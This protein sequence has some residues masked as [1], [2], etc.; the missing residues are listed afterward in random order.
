MR[1]RTVFVD[2]LPYVWTV[3]KV[4]E[5][6]RECG[7]IEEVRAP[8][9]Q[10]SGRLRGFAHVT[11]SDV[12]G[13]AKALKMD[14]TQVG[15][16]LASGWD[17]DARASEK[18]SLTPNQPEIVDLRVTSNGPRCRETY[19]F[20]A[21]GCAVRRPTCQERFPGHRD[22]YGFHS[23]G[24]ANFR[25]IP[26]HVVK[27]RR[28]PR[29]RRRPRMAA[30][31][32]RLAGAGGVRM[33]SSVPL[34][35]GGGDGGPP[36]QSHSAPL[37]RRFRGAPEASS[38]RSFG[39]RL[40]LPG[41]TR[42]GR[43]PL[44]G[45]E[46]EFEDEDAEQPSL[47]R[48]EKI[49]RDT[50][51]AARQRV[52][53]SPLRAL[54]TLSPWA[55]LRL[56]VFSAKVQGKSKYMSYNL[57]PVWNPPWEVTCAIYSPLS[58][59]QVLVKDHNN[60]REFT[61]MGFVEFRVADL[62]PGQLVTGSFE[63]REAKKLKVA[64]G[65]SRLLEHE[66]CRDEVRGLD[67]PRGSDELEDDDE[68]DDE[69]VSK[70][71][72]AVGERGGA[73]TR[74]ASRLRGLLH[75]VPGVV[76]SPTLQ[77]PGAFRFSFASGSLRSGEGEVRRA[78]AG[79]LNMQLQLMPCNSRSEQWDE[80]ELF[81]F[82]FPGPQADKLGAE[83]AKIREV[84][85]TIMSIKRM[86]WDRV[87]RRTLCFLVYVMEWRCKRLTTG[88]LVG[89]WVVAI[90]PEFLLPAVLLW[91]VLLI[92]LLRKKSWQRE[93]LDESTAPLTHEGFKVVAEF[94]NTRKMA[95]WLR[96]VAFSL[97]G[98][99]VPWDGVDIPPDLYRFASVIFRDKKPS[100]Q[101]DRVCE[102]LKQQKF[103]KKNTK[104]ITCPQG[105]VLEYD[106]DMTEGTPWRCRWKKCVHAFA[107]WPCSYGSVHRYQCL[108]CSGATRGSF[109]E[110]ALPGFLRA[111]GSNL[112]R[113][114]GG[115]SAWDLPALGPAPA[116]GH[117]LREALM[118]KLPSLARRR[119]V[120]APPAL[121]SAECGPA[122]FFICE[123]CV[124]GTTTSTKMWMRVLEG[125][126]RRNQPA[127]VR[128][129]ALKSG[130]YLT[131]G[132]NC[133]AMF[134]EWTL[135]LFYQE[136]AGL[137]RK[138]QL[139]CVGAAS[140]LLIGPD[141]PY[142]KDV[143][144]TIVSWGMA[145]TWCVL[146]SA[147]L[148]W[149][150][151]V[152]VRWRTGRK[153]KVL[154]KR[155]RKRRGQSLEDRWAFFTEDPSVADEREPDTRGG[156]LGCLARPH[157]SAPEKQACLARPHAPAWAP[158]PA[159]AA[160]GRVEPRRAEGAARPAREDLRL[161]LPPYRA[162]KYL[163][164]QLQRTPWAVPIRGAFPLELLKARRT[165]CTVGNK[166]R[167]LKIEAA[168]QPGAAAAAA[169]ADP[170]QFE[171]K[172]RLFVKNLPY[173]AAESEVLALFQK[174]GKVADV[175]IPTSFGRCKES[176]QSRTKDSLPDAFPAE[177]FQDTPDP[178]GDSQAS[179]IQ[180]TAQLGLAT[181]PAVADNQHQ[182]HT[183]AQ[184]QV[185]GTGAWQTQVLC[186][187]Q[188]QQP[189]QP[190]QQAWQPS[191]GSD[192]GGHVASG[193]GD[194]TAAAGA[195]ADAWRSQP[196][197]IQSA[198][199]QPPQQAP[200]QAWQP[201]CSSGG[202]GHAAAGAAGAAA[203]AGARQQ[204]PSTGAWQTQVPC[205][206]QLQQSQQQAWQSSCD[207]GIGGHV[208]AGA[209]DVLAAAGA[210][211]DAWQSQPWQSQS[212]ARQPPRE[213]PCPSGG[214]AAA[215]AQAQPAASLQA[216]AAGGR[217]RPRPARARDEDLQ[218][219]GDRIAS[220]FAAPPAAAAAAAARGRSPRGLGGVRRV[221]QGVATPQKPGQRWGRCPSRKRRG[222]GPL[223]DPGAA[224]LPRGGAAGGP[225]AAASCAAS[226]A[227]AAARESAGLEDA[228]SENTIDQK[229]AHRHNGLHAIM[230]GEGRADY[231]EAMRLVE[232]FL[233]PADEFPAHPYAVGLGL[234]DP[235]NLCSKR[236]WERSTQKWR[237]SLKA[238]VE[239]YRP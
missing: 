182:A 213:A 93:M 144:Y 220:A 20:P 113:L 183:T 131:K 47:H 107:E 87:V 172:R 178:Y 77:L 114:T 159:V 132:R 126:P 38:L 64:P 56:R 96:R 98:K 177:E 150:W 169:A 223:D 13:Q 5:H 196:R 84:Y 214:Q 228:E 239:K 80:D 231:Q 135:R 49:S 198:A 66:E 76:A 195:C 75:D 63:L 152:F 85:E 118:S 120:R 90:W 119:G 35:S 58:I 41:A 78:N 136:G 37:L 29:P 232:E 185:L 224:K 212:A 71:D 202:G 127:R 236:E 111:R 221:P 81:A 83:E 158:H 155:Y 216:A 124:L 165:S 101:F 229:R 97:H 67:E 45:S 167:Y 4:Q 88:I 24:P 209:G 217:G 205:F 6:F 36:E 23:Q 16:T 138:F 103:F 189:Q 171:G 134:L 105:H 129:F 173:D 109:A 181:E 180:T 52:L 141:I 102:L 9:W 30:S 237:K 199:R 79:T 100:I 163:G 104:N 70:D 10:D 82:C 219:A 34:L 15:G 51:H 156:Y 193:A 149:K 74:H 33:A 22:W 32:L 99:V 179:L 203:A 161:V 191:C 48:R 139:V 62:T 225:A 128:W 27:G 123:D 94:G 184:Q 108:Q 117:G 42:V 18:P 8:T 154:V 145:V 133:L 54:E 190:Q 115:V 12:R 14:G 50:F 168:K 187:L 166:G 140:L 204:V 153:A 106:A 68:D 211:A 230:H 19:E 72:S 86:L 65:S 208:A 25:P 186:F 157:A 200:Q 125:M 215:R 73:L 151:K 95:W 174:C 1:D 234:D 235:G 143:L 147:V 2:G 201:P 55:R 69:T 226:C 43:G 122:D 28:G 233:A 39:A 40:S 175:R 176:S 222:G 188:L 21:T 112:N 57:N 7:T 164:R 137:A 148:A 46:D 142:V 162:T 31:A 91:I 44:V 60:L 17:G 238:F 194:V 11:F 59:V 192:I 210:C 146:G 110:Q 207:S 61:L 3:E 89:W 121:V 160:A 116:A 227:A 170:K 197:Q 218:A 130:W 26:R 206:L 53:E 92:H